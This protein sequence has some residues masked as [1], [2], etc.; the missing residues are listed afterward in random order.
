MQK[1]FRQDNQKQR[2]RQTNKQTNKPKTRRLSRLYT[3][4]N[5]CLTDVIRRSEKF[6]IKFAALSSRTRVT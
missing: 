6:L 3:N 4:Q 5:C 1:Q 2:N